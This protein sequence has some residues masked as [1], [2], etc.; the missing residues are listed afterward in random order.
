MSRIVICDL[1]LVNEIS[2][3]QDLTEAES[4]IINGG[5]N[6]KTRILLFVIGF[7]QGFAE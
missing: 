5:C 7:M 2:L 3:M 1:A 4:N 6:L